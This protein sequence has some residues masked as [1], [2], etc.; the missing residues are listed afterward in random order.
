MANAPVVP[1]Y[2][3]MRRPVFVHARHCTWCQ[4]ETRSAFA[5]NALIG[6]ANVEVLAG[7]PEAVATT[8][9]SG[10]G[11]IVLRCPA[12]RVALWSHFGGAGRVAFVRVARLD[13]PSA[14]PPDIHIFTSTKQDW[15]SLDGRV[16]V[17]ADYAVMADYPVMADYH[18]WKKHLPT[19]RIARRETMLAGKSEKGGAQ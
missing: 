14:C 19:E 11:Q 8:S 15:L 13:A 17:M 3:M 6:A 1:R 5:L 7:A 9:H 4:R 16:P 2:L 18:D 12:C 10:Q